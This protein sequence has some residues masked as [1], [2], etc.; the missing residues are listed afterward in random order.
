MSFEYVLLKDSDVFTQSDQF[1]AIFSGENPLLQN[2]VGIPGKAGFGVG[3]AAP[4]VVAALNLVELEGTKDRESFQFGLYEYSKPVDDV[5]TVDSVGTVTVNGVVTINALSDDAGT[6]G[7][8]DGSSGAGIT[9]NEDSVDNGVARSVTQSYRLYLKYIPR[10]YVKLLSRS[11]DVLLTPEE[12]EALLPYVPVTLEQLQKAQEIAG[13]AALV[14]SKPGV[15]TS[16]EDAQLH[17]F[18]HLDAF[19]DGGKE[20]D[21]FFIQN[22]LPMFYYSTD[23]TNTDTLYCLGHPSFKFQPRFLYETQKSG[24]VRCDAE[25]PPKE[26]GLG[27]TQRLPEDIARKFPGTNLA[28]VHMVAALRVLQFCEMLYGE[29]SWGKAPRGI[30]SNGSTDID[31]ATVLANSN[32]SSQTGDIWVQDSEQYKKTTHNGQMNG[33]TNVNGWVYQMVLGADSSWQRIMTRDRKLSEVTLDNAL[34]D[35]GVAAPAVPD[36]AIWG[37]N[38]L[39]QPWYRGDPHLF[40]V[41]PYVSN[42]STNPTDNFGDDTFRHIDGYQIAAVG[43]CFKDGTSAGIFASLYGSNFEYSSRLMSFRLAMYPEGNSDKVSIIPDMQGGV[44]SRVIEVPQ[45][46]TWKDVEPQLAVPTFEGKRFKWWS[47]SVGGDEV[48]DDVVFSENTIVAAVW[49]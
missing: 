35:G 44:G 21:G 34:E 6:E 29:P 9:D 13:T 10:F 25:N 39:N 28:T 12:L 16:K 49:M 17:G 42:S 36:N 19:I 22:T 2:S 27:G 11:D 24:I 32:V 41:V 47:L 30:N 45:G 37:H 33:L 40:G 48:K 1:I 7:N 46:T 15:F 8:E 43:R 31:D 23:G 18:M 20:V 5:K 38:E 14:I 4:E 3:I 26:F